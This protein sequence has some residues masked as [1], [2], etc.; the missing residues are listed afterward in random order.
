[1]Q[2]CTVPTEVP[3]LTAS[4][5]RLAPPAVYASWMERRAS[6]FKYV[7]GGRPI[8][9]PFARPDPLDDQAPLQLGYCTQHCEDHFPGRR[10]GVELLRERDEV[11][12]QSAEGLQRS[13]QMR[14]G[15]SKPV[16]LPTNDYIE[17]PAVRV[18]HEPIKFGPFLLRARDPYINV[19]AYDAPAA[20]LAVL[21]EF[22]RL[23]AR[24]LALIGCRDAGIEGHSHLFS[25]STGQVQSVSVRSASRQ[26][27]AQRHASIMLP[28]R[29]AH[30]SV[31]R[32]FLPV[33][34][35]K[36]TISVTIPARLSSRFLYD[37]R[38]G[39]CTVSVTPP[40]SAQSRGK[41]RKLPQ[42]THSMSEPAWEFQYSIECNAPQKFAWRFWTNVANWNDPPAKFD[43]D[44]PFEIGARLTTTLP[45]QTL[46]SV[47]RDLQPE[48]EAA[49]EMQ[50]PDAILSFH[51]KFEKLAENRTR[52]IQRLV[53]SGANAK[54]F[55]AQASAMEASVP[56]GMKKVVAAIE[57]AQWLIREGPSAST[58]GIPPGSKT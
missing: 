32:P 4:W 7:R 28:V 21:P 16:E 9:L 26:H 11:D 35:S 19:F 34:M 30:T 24:V 18:G 37:Y 57:R 8:R 14:H 25:H 53:L 45:G 29:L 48:R 50:L 43:L 20:A 5:R 13:K 49:I 54:S 52:I 31:A 1:M 23:H 3:N 22:K 47:I 44:G 41:V 12:T 46:Y 36:R 33:T 27:Y 42:M 10:A 58:E 15:A 56:D 38:Y 55:V 39:R 40:I 2:R 17:A 51:W 6:W